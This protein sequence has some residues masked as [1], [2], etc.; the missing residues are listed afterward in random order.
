MQPI[1][2]KEK[3]GKRAREKTDLVQITYCESNIC[4]LV[5]SIRVGFTPGCGEKGKQ[6]LAFDQCVETYV[7][8]GGHAEGDESN[9]LTLSDQFSKIRKCCC[10]LAEGAC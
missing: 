4:R 10:T 8:E 6:E 3:E 1:R 5:K 9:G 2:E 7:N